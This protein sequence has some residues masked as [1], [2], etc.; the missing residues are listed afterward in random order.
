M[1]FNSKLTPLTLPISTLI[2]SYVPFG[3]STLTSVEPAGAPTFFEFAS[4][5]PA[6]PVE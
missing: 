3:I 4:L 1:S 2:L 5:Y 6:P